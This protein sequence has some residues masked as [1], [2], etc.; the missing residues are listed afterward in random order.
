MHSLKKI[1]KTF[2]LLIS[3]QKISKKNSTDDFIEKKFDTQP[4][5]TPKKDGRFFLG[6]EGVGI[7][8]VRKLFN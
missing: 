6:G 5:P 2:A 1:Q 8:K 7:F 4:P 3:L